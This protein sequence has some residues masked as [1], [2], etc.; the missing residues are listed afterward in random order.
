[1]KL[2]RKRLGN[3]RGDENSLTVIKRDGRKAKFDKD[4]IKVAVLKAFIDVDGE[5]TTYAKEKAR[6]IANYIES[7]NKDMSVEE[8]QDVVVNKLM[9]SS[10]KDVAAKYVEYRYKRKLVRESNTTDKTILEIIEGDSD[11]WNGENSNKNPRLNTTIRDYM[12]GETSTDISRRI[13]LPKE[14]IEAHDKGEIHFH[15]MD[16]FAQHMHNC[17]LI[18]LEDMLQNNTVISETLIESPHS[19]STA[20]T[21]ATQIIAQ[22]ASAQYGGQ[23]VSLA[24]LAPFVDVS[25]KAI[26]KEVTEEL[27]DNGFIHEY[28]EN[29]AE[30]THITNDRLSKEIKKGIQTIQYQVV[31]LMTTNGQAPFLTLFM[32]LNE[33]K[34]EQEKNDLAMLIE[35]TLNQRYQGV[36]NEKGVWI[37]PA[38]P[39]IIYVLEEDNV[40]EN[41]K[42]WYLTKLAAK[43]SAK[44]LVP[45]YISEKVMKELKDG[46]C[47]P[48]MGCV[49]GKEIVS[50]KY[51]GNLYVESF[52][53]M[54]NRL[55]DHFEVK[56]QFNE[57]NPNIYMDL[58]NI[59]IYDTEKGFVNTERIIRNI[60]SNWVDVHFSN[61][62]R[63]LCTT[64]HPFEVYNKGVVK[65]EN[66]SCGNK[67][68]IN[69]SQVNDER[70][71]FN[72]DK[73]WLLGFMLC[74][75]CYQNNSL[76]ASI[77]ADGED[78]IENKFISAF[79]SHFGLDVKTVLQERGKKGVYKDLIV[80]SDN[81]GGIQRVCSYLNEKF[82]GVNKVNRHIPN[83][84][85][86][87]N[88][89]SKLAFLAGMIDAD[90]YINDNSHGGSVVQ[91]GSTNKE[92]ALQQMEL[93][94][95]LGMPAKIYHNHYTKKNPN[96]IRYRVEFYPIEELLTFVVCNKKLDKY[97]EMISDHYNTYS[98][99][100]EVIPVEKTDYSYDVTTESGHFEVS[101]IYSH[102]C[103]SALTVWKDENGNPK[104]YGRFNQ[105]V[106]TINLVD[107][108]LSSEG[109]FNKF[110]ELFDERTE[111]CHKALQCRHERLEGT[112]SDV[113]PILWQ[114][115]ALSRL[116][117][118]EKIDKLLHG[119]YS[120]ISLGYAGLY[121]C[122]KYMTGFS[123]SDEGVGEKFGLKV[124]QAL[125]DK[126]KQWKEAENIDYSLYGTPLESTTYKFAKLLKKKFGND[127]FI[128]IDNH[129]R[130]YITNSYHI[131]VFEEIDAF[132]KLRIEA[133]FQRLSPGG[134]I[135]YIE[136]PNMN[137]N[138]DA[139][140][141]VI[142][143]IYDNIMYAELNTK[144][145]YCQVCGYDGEISLID[146]N[147][148]LLWE[149]PKCHNRDPRTM[150]ITRRTCGYIGTGTNGW[151]QGRLGD[152]HDRIL[153]LDNIEYKGCDS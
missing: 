22:V 7:L 103:R 130:N 11:Y 84:V 62:R 88:Y 118:G 140:L 91:I 126:C 43:C 69:S 66:L 132:E 53:R 9:A 127:I 35:E 5:E 147:N 153:H 105:G 18:N 39:K 44:R 13:L 111:L 42:Y 128:R 80:I 100:V 2:L 137:D 110:W 152:I 122:V 21:V 27:Y 142:K 125:N 55:S 58:Q 67:V 79:K 33:A 56:H 121:E 26:R 78:E 32:Y 34:N 15:D 6:D 151:N 98:E 116:D 49:D 95:S 63:L 70:I 8:I 97:E 40:T 89:E 3:C 104:F 136:T 48:V 149:C 102:N 115:G 113:A 52:E 123:H 68:L 16:Y 76:F 108:A 72:R 75:G 146:E 92:L 73:A 112:S 46:N 47:Y 83:E 60:S 24:H 117:R 20:C 107:I 134:A 12:A 141:E 93:A 30:V 133:K 10:R 59:E 139:V 38:F 77:A 54:W 4:K 114:Y 74:D 143:F 19:F 129:D 29:L 81:N 86:E 37:S 28:N 90:G 145:D 148:K 150:N 1:M 61:G 25:R 51:L 17:D 99:V 106:V 87:W 120:T 124:M 131:P 45:D 135:S 71:I 31:T 85:F 64:D 50:Y 23:S 94:Q 41:S 82:G 119:G 109:D 14:V 57:N 36:K 65:A 101:G 144:S 96:A 138:I